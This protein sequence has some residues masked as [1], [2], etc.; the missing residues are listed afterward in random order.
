MRNVPIETLEQRRGTGFLL[1]IRQGQ[2]I[3][4]CRGDQGWKILA[5]L[6]SG[7]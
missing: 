6:W 4:V 5:L 2:K 7:T 3:H 1:K